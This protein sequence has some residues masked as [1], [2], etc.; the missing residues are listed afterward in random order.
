MKD[1]R[2]GE[3]LIEIKCGPRLNLNSV[4]RGI[5]LTEDRKGMSTGMMKTGEVRQ[6][7][8]SE[9]QGTGWTVPTVGRGARC[10]VGLQEHCLGQHGSK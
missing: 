1:C 3:A 8:P 5:G 4:E 7:M 2:R 10:M 9:D 6:S